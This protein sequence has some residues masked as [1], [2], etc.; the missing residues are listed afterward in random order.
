MKRMAKS[1]KQNIL[2]FDTTT[3]AC[4]VA[5]KS[6]GQVYSKHVEEA[7]IHSQ[8]LLA[9]VDELLKQADIK[10]ND[11]DYLAVGVGP[12][13]FTGLRI[14][15]GVAQ[16]LA[17]CHELKIIAIS[18]LE[19][20][21]ISALSSLSDI[22]QGMVFAAHDA[23]M[24]EAYIAKFELQPQQRLQLKN[25]IELQRP[26]QI[27]IFSIQESVNKG[28][29]YF[30][31]GNAWQIYQEKMPDIFYHDSYLRDVLTPHAKDVV[32]YIECYLLDFD[33][34]Q[35]QKLQPVYVRNNV[36]KKSKKKKY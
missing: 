8:K 34:I 20:L 9:M 21:A 18:S 33:V 25:D 17:Y 15:V 28:V 11:I 1:E 19:M 27:D 7:N 29:N 4:T 30:L 26:E 12:G 5:L 13:S 23:R 14:G 36:A 10:L 3:V 6:A 24:S 2:V 32:E 31:C 35:W 16:A 22:Q